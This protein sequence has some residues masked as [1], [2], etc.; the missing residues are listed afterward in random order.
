MQP[1]I[2]S[3]TRRVFRVLPA[4]VGENDARDACVPGSRTIYIRPVSHIECIIRVHVKTLQHE[5][6]ASRV[7]LERL[8]LR[9]L[10]ADH[11]GKEFFEAQRS[12]L[13]VR[14]IVG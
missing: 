3:Y 14:G 10:R 1:V 5:L 8:N 9:I 13:G 12:E 4:A 6:Q 2:S 11:H 7:G